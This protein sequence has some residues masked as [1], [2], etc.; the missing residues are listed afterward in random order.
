[1]IQKSFAMFV[2][3]GALAGCQIPMQSVPLHLDTSGAR[4]FVDG[5]RVD[6]GAG[7]LTLRS[8]RPHVVHIERDGHQAQQVVL[9]S[10][11]T[12]SGPRLEPAEIRVRLAPVVPT[13]R[14]IQIQGADAD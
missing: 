7:S 10:R 4:V 12:P 3:V 8:D 1:M 9:E 6:S 2:L 11:E 5:V 14:Q 13:E